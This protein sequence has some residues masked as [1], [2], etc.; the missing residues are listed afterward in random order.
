MKHQCQSESLVFTSVEEVEN[1]WPAAADPNKKQPTIEQISQGKIVILTSV[2]GQW[3]GVVP[4]EK[5]IQKIKDK[6]G[7]RCTAC[8]EA[9]GFSVFQVRQTVSLSTRDLTKDGQMTKLSELA[10]DECT[11]NYVKCNCCGAVFSL[12]KDDDGLFR[13]GSKMYAPPTPNGFVISPVTTLHFHESEVADGFE[14]ETMEN[15]DLTA[16]MLPAG[17]DEEA[18]EEEDDYDCDNDEEDEQDEDAI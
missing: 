17:W 10:E 15:R 1:F 4:K 5:D 12:A 2:N 8:D 3:F 18:E 11:T 16:E 6:I 7:I 9:D 14:L 13:P